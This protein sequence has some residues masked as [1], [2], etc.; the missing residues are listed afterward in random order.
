MAKNDKKQYKL[1]TEE[2]IKII[3]PDPA[4]LA[5]YVV[6][7]KIRSSRKSALIIC[8]IG[9]ILAF[10]GISVHVQ[11]ISQITDTKINLL[12]QIF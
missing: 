8:L 6:A 10:G 4:G 1:L 5:D 3:E 7:N 12:K 11:V 9:M 2:D